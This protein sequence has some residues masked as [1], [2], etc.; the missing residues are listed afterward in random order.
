MER[1][2]ENGT[3]SLFCPNEAQGLADTYGGEFEACITSTKKRKEARKTINAQDL[4]FAILE[5]Q[6][7]TGT[8]IYCIK[9][10]A[11]EKSNQKIWEPSNQVISVQKSWNIHLLTKWQFVIW[12]LFLCQSLWMS[13]IKPLISKRCIKLQPLSPGI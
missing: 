11:N 13:K 4:W 12:L 7:E 9:M 10:P 2:K 8:P 3:W 6:I 5:S 1:V